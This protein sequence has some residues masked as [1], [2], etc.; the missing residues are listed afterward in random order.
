MYGYHHESSDGT[1][2]S[3]EAVSPSPK[4]S[5]SL[6]S[7][8]FALCPYLGHQ[9]PAIKTCL[10]VCL[11]SYYLAWTQK[12]GQNGRLESDVASMTRSTGKAAQVDSLNSGLASFPDGFL[13]V[14]NQ[15]PTASTRH[16]TD[17]L[18]AEGSSISFDFHAAGLLPYS[19]VTIEINATVSGQARADLDA[20]QYAVLV[21]FTLPEHS[22]SSVDPPTSHLCE[23]FR[24][25][26]RGHISARPLG[27]GMKTCEPGHGVVRSRNTVRG[28]APVDRAGARAQET[29]AA[30]SP[31]QLQC[32]W[33]ARVSPVFSGTHS[34]TIA[35]I[36]FFRRA[37]LE[38]VRAARRF[39]E[40]CKLANVSENIDYSRT[41]VRPEV[42]M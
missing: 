30:L 9:S 7:L 36:R 8:S 13:S 28:D 39:R 41:S 42:H 20:W 1:S 17:W 32:R 12:G 22:S 2:E 37:L 6:H 26:Y 23:T 15:H 25:M 38:E 31:A 35:V 24:R 34:L 3:R 11:A 40:D 21:R 33:N 27:R 29:R 5:L 14:T 18:A 4:P 19:G 10:A 16:E